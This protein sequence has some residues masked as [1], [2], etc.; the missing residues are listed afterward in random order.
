MSQRYGIIDILKSNLKTIKVNTIPYVC[1]NGCIYRLYVW[2]F[3]VEVPEDDP[4][5]TETCRNVSELHVKV[6]L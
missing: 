6:C 2:L 1:M 4:K 3:D 5:K